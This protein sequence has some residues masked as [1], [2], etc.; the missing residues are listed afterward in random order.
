M[1]VALSVEAH[2]LGAL[3]AAASA[4]G[5]VVTVED[6]MVLRPSNGVVEAVR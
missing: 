2:M 5:T 4:G 1:G 3:Q 6:R